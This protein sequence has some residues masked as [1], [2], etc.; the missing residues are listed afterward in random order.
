[1]KLNAEKTF[2]E[3]EHIK[4]VKEQILIVPDFFY[5]DVKIPQR[6]HILT[7]DEILNQKKKVKALEKAEIEEE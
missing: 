4:W 2:E 3:R 7:L 6:K 1:M 5:S